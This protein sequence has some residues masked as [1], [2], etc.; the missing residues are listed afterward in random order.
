MY[1]MGLRMGKIVEWVV[2]PI[3]GFPPKGIA[4]TKHS[5]AHN[6]RPYG[7]LLTRKEYI[8][9]AIYRSSNKKSPH[10][11]P[12]T[13]GY[14]DFLCYI[15]ILLNQFALGAWLRSV[16][17]YFSLISAMVPSSLSTAKTRFRVS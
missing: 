17:K 4:Q 13:A 9:Q 14:G 16:P 10:P 2:S 12:N 15:V 3:T 1:F 8:S 6:A 5:Q 11:L 7:N